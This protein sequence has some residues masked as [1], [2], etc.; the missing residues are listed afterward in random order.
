MVRQLD[1]DPLIEEYLYPIE[2]N[3]KHS[4]HL[5]RKDI[6]QSPYVIY[7]QQNPIGY[8]DI[9]HIIEFMKSVNLSYALLEQERGKGYATKVLK[10]ITEIIL[11][12]KINDIEKVYLV[13]NY[14][15][16]PS[17]MV[18]KKSGFMD[19]GLSDE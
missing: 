8:I 10:A 13:I 12:D 6:Y 15:N 1:K 19:D 5:T 18:A 14:D 2:K 17:Q 11:G 3:L 9:S 7:H 16:I 4:K